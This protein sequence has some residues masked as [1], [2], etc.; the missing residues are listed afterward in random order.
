MI[1]TRIPA[2]DELVGREELVIVLTVVS[3]LVIVVV[4]TEGGEKG[5]TIFGI[6]GVVCTTVSIQM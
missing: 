1:P 3:L 4:V 2:P 5:K 6:R